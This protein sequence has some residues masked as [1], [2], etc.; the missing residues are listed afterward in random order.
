VLVV[1]YNPLGTELGRDFKLDYVFIP[2]T[3]H[4]STSPTLVKTDSRPTPVA[5]QGT[6][7]VAWDGQSPLAGPAGTRP[8]DVKLRLG[9]LLTNATIVSAE[10]SNLHGHSWTTANTFLLPLAVFKPAG[11]STADLYFPPTRDELGS[12]LT[13]RLKYSNGSEV[14]T[15]FDGGASDVHLRDLPASA[16]QSMVTV[17]PNGTTRN[18]VI[19]VGTGVVSLQSLLAMTDVS[20]VRFSA[21][22]YFFDQRIT[23]NRNGSASG[24]PEWQFPLRVDADANVNLN[25]AADVGAFRIE[26]G[27]VTLDGLGISVTVPQ[28]GNG[29]T[30]IEIAPGVADTTLSHLRLTGPLPSFSNQVSTKLIAVDGTLQSRSPRSTHG[31][32]AGNTLR[33]GQLELKGGPWDVVGNDYQGAHPNAVAEQVI[34]L[35]VGHDVAIRAN[36]ARNVGASG[37]TRGFLVIGSST[38]VQGFGNTVEDNVIE[39]GIGQ[40]NG[41]VN[42]PEMILTES[43]LPIFEG[44]SYQVFANDSILR[45]PHQRGSN[46]VL[47]GDV[48]AILS[49]PRAGQWRQI[50]QVIG[51]N[52]FLLDRPVPTGAAIAVHRGY[53]NHTFRGNLIDMTDPSLASTNFGL[54]LPGN[55]YGLRVIGNTFKGRNAIDVRSAVTEATSQ[56]IVEEAPQSW[57]RTP[58]FGIVIDRNTFDNVTGS[59]VGAGHRD[60]PFPTSG[61]VYFTGSW[62]DT[63]I[64]GS[65]NPSFD[66]GTASS[67]MPGTFNFVP[68]FT[69]SNYPWIDPGEGRLALAWPNTGAHT[70]MAYAGSFNGVAV[71]AGGETRAP[72]NG[73]GVVGMMVGQDNRDLLLYGFPNVVVAGPD[74]RQQLDNLQDL[75]FRIT[76]LTVP[77]GRTVAF[78]KVAGNGDIWSNKSTAIGNGSLEPRLIVSWPPGS[79]AVDLYLQ[80]ANRVG[81]AGDE[82]RDDAL[83]LLTYQVT[84]EFDNGTTSTVSVAGVFSDQLRRRVPGI[85]LPRAV[86]DYDGDGKSDLATAVDVGANVRWTVQRSRDNLPPSENYGASTELAVIPADYDGDGLTDFAVFDQAAQWVIRYSAGGTR[87]FQFGATTDRPIPADYDGDGKADLAVF[88]EN[89]AHWFILYSGGGVLSL[90]FGAANLDRPVPGDGTRYR[91]ELRPAGGAVELLTEGYLVDAAM[92]EISSWSLAVTDAGIE[93]IRRPLLAAVASGD[94]I[95]LIL[96]AT[97]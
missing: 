53:L 3:S 71:A 61:R 35:S 65:T 80:P 42:R 31:R 16:T 13:L 14:F 28:Q 10:L 81:L 79:S 89:E 7:T 11:S 9:G 88:R 60:L 67:G 5:T 12:R 75:H 77:A 41:G 58:M 57:S 70:I 87:T 95:A 6:F 48:V 68:A 85:D 4:G 56:A 59:E 52:T 47:S 21:G 24:H 26:T 38:D 18:S 78:V 94:A 23:I 29:G 17:I 83:G 2:K 43:Y 69:R 86:S 50:V 93:P 49:G 15:Q 40:R 63:K 84:V 66:F 25:W 51:E 73:T 55:H 37:E 32:I 1:R 30:L 72:N 90:Q 91:I 74:N 45:I 20:H 62:T 97:L 82:L 46:N 22:D 36:R 54:V 33:G 8:G 64:L 27:H 92:A 39:G 76:G 34:G 44:T 96:E 19:R